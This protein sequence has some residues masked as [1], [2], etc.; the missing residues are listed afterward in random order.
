MGKEGQG[1]LIQA[2]CSVAL[3]QNMA[4]TRLSMYIRRVGG[5]DKTTSF[6]LKGVFFG[7]EG[8]G[9]PVNTFLKHPPTTM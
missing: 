8:T 3:T 2:L 9:L 1:D 5:R 4:A 6:G 7:G